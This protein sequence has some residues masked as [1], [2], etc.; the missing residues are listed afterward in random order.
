[1]HARTHHDSQ[2]RRLVTAPATAAGLAVGLA[3]G[4]G[5]VFGAEAPDWRRWHSG[6]EGFKTAMAEQRD[7]QKAMF[8]YFY[9]D[10]CGYC[11][12]FERELL[13][14]DV[15]KDYLDS[16]VKVRINPEAGPLEAQIQQMYGV[17]GYPTL[18]MHSSRTK[19]LSRVTRHE[20]VEGGMRL[21]EGPE[22]VREL[23][24]AASR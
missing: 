21:L 8:V 11:R 6:A 17:S 23:K 9:T 4:A 7:S 15:V 13:T 16:I 3:L 24:N 19:S 1:M 22:F 14:E 18:L 12:Q 5:A 2:T 10:W 20:E